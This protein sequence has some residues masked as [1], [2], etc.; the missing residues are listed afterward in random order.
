M[1]CAL[2][3]TSGLC[4]LQTT[5]EWDGK[6]EEVS[7]LQQM[8]EKLQNESFDERKL[9][10][11]GY[12]GSSCC[13]QDLDSFWRLVFLHRKRKGGWWY[14]WQKK[15]RMSSSHDW[16]CLLWVMKGFRYI[17]ALLLLAKKL[18]QTAKPRK[19][20]KMPLK[21]HGISLPSQS[22]LCS[23]A[24]MPRVQWCDRMMGWGTATCSQGSQGS[25]HSPHVLWEWGCLSS[26]HF[27]VRC[28][29]CC[30]SPGQRWTSPLRSAFCTCHCC[31][32][33][34][35]FTTQG[36]STKCAFSLWNK[37]SSSGALYEPDHR[38]LQWDRSS[39]KQ[40]K[41]KSTVLSGFV[42]SQELF[43]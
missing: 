18:P 30:W 17:I 25:R 24:S 20:Q 2:L 4:W 5:A 15:G 1:V 22:P 16:V 11:T 23:H 26:S 38:P 7:G 35:L 31:N 19:C 33:A 10:Q 42:R 21:V 3:V 6:G 43:S 39:L 41:E 29:H 36:T 34:K 8:G 32:R 9:R 40:Y 13:S 37:P 27:V 28:C 14:F 12:S